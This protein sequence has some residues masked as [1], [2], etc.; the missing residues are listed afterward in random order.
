MEHLIFIQIYI[1]IYMNI[2]EIMC[3]KNIYICTYHCFSIFSIPNPVKIIYSASVSKVQMNKECLRANVIELVL[4]CVFECYHKQCKHVYLPKTNT[5]IITNKTFLAA[6]KS[7]LT[8]V[9][10]IINGMSYLPISIIS[11]TSQIPMLEIAFNYL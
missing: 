8:I 1:Y 10:L 11:A 4:Q 6:T 9:I 5:N 3:F 2:Y 7:T